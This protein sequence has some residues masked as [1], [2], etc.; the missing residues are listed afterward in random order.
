MNGDKILNNDYLG[1]LVRLAIGLIFI[2]ASLDKIWSPGDFA[3][4]MY[5]YHLVPGSLINL[6]ALILPWVELLCGLFLVLGVFKEG[7]LLI[8]NLLVI[9]FIVAISIN[10]VRGVDLECGCFSVSSKAKSSALSLLLRDLGL[11]ILTLY[12]FF[13]RSRRFML[14]RARR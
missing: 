1:L 7:S 14:A 9:V 2:Y 13:N 5:N 11:L 4:I 8:L 12:V 3:R 10:L 6:T